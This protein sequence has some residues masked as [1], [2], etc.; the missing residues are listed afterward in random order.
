MALRW[1]KLQDQLSP[2]H[3]AAHLGHVGVLRVLIKGYHADKLAEAMVNECQTL[4]M[5]YIGPYCTPM[6]TFCI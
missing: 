6:Y 2:V 5:V 3:V 4:F 1:N